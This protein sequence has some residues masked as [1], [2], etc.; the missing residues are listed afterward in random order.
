MK[1]SLRGRDHVIGKYSGGE[2]GRGREEG[3][4]GGKGA[5][6]GKKGTESMG[7]NRGRLSN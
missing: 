6:R 2:E 5:G 1:C 4:G 7:I 3:E